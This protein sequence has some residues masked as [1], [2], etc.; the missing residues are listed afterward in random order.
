M[1][2][3]RASTWNLGQQSGSK[4][5][6][7]ASSTIRKGAAQRAV[8]RIN[9]AIARQSSSTVVM[10]EP[11]TPE[12]AGSS[13]APSFAH[14][15][16]VNRHVLLSTKARGTAGFSFI[17]RT[18]RAGIPADSQPEPLIPATRSPGLLAG[19]P[20]AAG[21][22]NVRVCRDFRLLGKR[23]RSHPALAVRRNTSLPQRDSPF[24]P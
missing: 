5:L 22:W 7:S 4:R 17:P 14:K 11:V 20:L 19:H 16:P 3:C 6:E 10:S 13:P 18:S 8:S 15:S 12:V 1:I 21:I 23:S 24:W 2:A 9:R